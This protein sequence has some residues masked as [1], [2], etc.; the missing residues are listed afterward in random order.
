MQATW[1]ANGI[2]A[3]AGS[4][5]ALLCQRTKNGDFRVQLLELTRSTSR[6]AYF[7]PK[8][9]LYVAP[10]K[11]DAVAYVK[12]YVETLGWSLSKSR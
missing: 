7:Q 1:Q 5:V 12:R 6:R 10:S 3:P 2:I 4:N 8:A 9:L 11:D